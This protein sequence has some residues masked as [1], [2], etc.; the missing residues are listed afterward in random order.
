MLVLQSI[1]GTW[2]RSLGASANTSSRLADIPHQIKLTISFMSFN[3][4]Y[5]DAGLFGIYSLTE[6]KDCQGDSI[7][8]VPLGPRGSIVRIDIFECLPDYVR[9]ANNMAWNRY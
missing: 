9:T 5:T 4:S 6:N 2:D 7:H 3:T 8:S 1:I